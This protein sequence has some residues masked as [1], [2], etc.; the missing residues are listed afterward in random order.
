MIAVLTKWQKNAPTSISWPNTLTFM[1][2]YSENNLPPNF[3]L[4]EYF[5]FLAYVDNLTK[6]LPAI[7]LL[8]NINANDTE[9]NV[10]NSRVF[11]IDE[12]FNL[13][14]ELSNANET[15]RNAL[16][17]MFDL[18]RTVKIINDDNIILDII[19]KSVSYDEMNSIITT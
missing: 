6:S 13:Y 7:N 9:G 18:T 5:A 14:K 16:L 10:I 1:N 19:S 17:Q 12:E 2:L 11:T 8:I 15:E 3:T 4:V